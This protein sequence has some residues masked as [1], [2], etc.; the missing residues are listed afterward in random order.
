MRTRIPVIALT[1]YLGSGKTTVLNHLLR[2][3]GTRAGVVVND[4]GAV[5][6]D[7]GLVSGQVDQPMSISGGCLCCLPAAGGLDLALERLAHPRLSLDAIIV[8]ASGVADPLALSRLIRTSTAPGIRPAGVIEVVDVVEYF[9]TVDTRFL[10][11]ARLAAASLVLLNKVDRLDGGQDS[12]ELARITGRIRQVNPRVMV[13]PTVGGR[14]DPTLVFDIAGDED[15]QDQLPLAQLSRQWHPDREGEH[16]H[17]RPHAHADTV[18]VTTPSPANPFRLLALLRE[19]LPEVY[20]LKGQVSVAAPG[21]TRRFLVNSV[22][23]D[24][25]LEGRPDSPDQPGGELVAIGV[26]M[27]VSHT[28]TLL[29]RALEGSTSGLP[30]SALTDALHQLDHLCRPSI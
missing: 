30:S 8:E 24:V 9:R 21:G 6:V 19:R 25:R 12:P 11:P 20:R 22:G 13:V 18:T 7:A 3:E 23:G 17:A 15:P 26:H 14:I 29:E 2:R 1:G 4:F 16:D 27:D 28:R 5:N 10:P